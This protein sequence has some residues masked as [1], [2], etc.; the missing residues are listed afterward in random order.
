M[1]TAAAF[2]VAASVGAVVRLA[3]RQGAPSL[4][5]LPLGTLVVNVVG[6][7]AAGLTASWAPPVATVVVTGGLGALT[8]FSTLAS[9]AVTVWD[10][11]RGEAV[12]Y[13]TVTIV[14]GVFAA[15]AGLRLGT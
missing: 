4:G 5:G 8:T 10:A 15:W 9:E 2:V 7:L 3:L 14:A 12:V 13:V 1:V 11:R 6:A